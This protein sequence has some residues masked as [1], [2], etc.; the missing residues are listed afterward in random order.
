MFG[1][2]AFMLFLWPLE[3]LIN[4]KP[5]IVGWTGF[6]LREQEA[7]HFDYSRWEEGKVVKL[8][9][10]NLNA[11]FTLYMH[12][13]DKHEGIMFSQLKL[14]SHSFSPAFKSEEE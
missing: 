11:C 10:K 7:C 8:I 6:N 14:F 13:E 12:Y 5:K 3:L 4:W 9:I 2:L 1:Q